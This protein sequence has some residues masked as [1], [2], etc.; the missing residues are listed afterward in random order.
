MVFKPI[1]FGQCFCWGFFNCRSFPWMKQMNP[2]GHD[3]M[4]QRWTLDAGV[5]GR[6]N[7]PISA[8]CKMSSY[9]IYLEMRKNWWLKIGVHM[10][11]D[12]HMSWFS[13]S[14]LM[15]CMFGWRF[16]EHLYTSV[17]TSWY[18][19]SIICCIPGSRRMETWFFKVRWGKASHGPLPPLEALAFLQ[20][21][22]DAR[23]K[24]WSE[25]FCAVST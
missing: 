15:Q 14:I 18:P 25:T 22:E 23:R 9:I 13:L 20:D 16:W 6:K 24:T 1:F 12:M 10:L 2:W 19:I 4:S 17:V 7:P 5:E 8:C 3:C 11:C 21:I